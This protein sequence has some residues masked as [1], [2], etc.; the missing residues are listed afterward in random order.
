MGKLKSPPKPPAAPD[1]ER[2][3]KADDSRE[4]SEGKREIGPLPKVKNPARKA[5]GKKSLKAF[6]KAYFPRRF[7]LGFS[8]A[9]DTAIERMEG[10]TDNGELFAC[11]MPRGFGKTTIA[12]VAV[13]RA[14]LYGK[15]RFVVLVCATGPLAQRRL[16]Q[17][18]RELETNDLLLEDFPE[19]CYPIRKLDR[20]HNRAKGQTLNG[21]PTRMELNRDGIILPTV[22]GAA[23]SGA[24]IQVAGM[25]SAIR[26]MNVGGPDGEPL[27]PDM[28]VI[29][30][31]QTRDSA[32]SPIQTN[33]REAIV[34]G[35]VLGLAG[36]DVSMA[37]VMLCTV[38]YPGDL[39]E[40]FLDPEKHPEWQGVRT[41]TLDSF[42]A[43][44]DLWDEYA[45][46]RRQSFRDGSKGRRATEFYKKNRA[47][48]DAGAAPTWQDKKKPNELSAVQSAMNWFYTSRAA[49]MA[50]GQN[51]P[52]LDSGS[53][54]AK[55]LVP[56]EVTK[57]LSGCDRYVVPP[58]V[59]RLTAFIDCGGGKGRGLWYAVCG[60]TDGFG[61][62]VI[63]YGTWPRQVRTVFAADDMRPGLAELYPTLSVSERLYKGLTDLAAEV[64]PREYLRERTAER[65]R[66]ER[67]LVDV[68]WEPKTVWSWCR[69][70]PFWPI[71]TPSK[72]IA[73]TKTAKGVAEWAS[74]PGEPRPGHHW[75]L[76]ASELGQGR[77]CQFDTD[78]WKSILWER[79]TSPLGGA[80]CLHL[81]GKAGPHAPTHELLGEHLAA[82]TAEPVTIRGSTFDKWTERPHRPDNHWF[83]GL[84]GCAVGASMQGVTF[85][86][87]TAAG[88]PVQALAPVKVMSFSEMQRAARAARNGG[89]R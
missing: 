16:K 32:K 89:R 29:D 4:R 20:I 5:R 78:A 47:E 21:K 49:F 75:R 59:T 3:R 48:M 76:T 65:L 50:E 80:G 13:L 34:T 54:G 63:D 79:L 25:E 42:P 87:G 24:V 2:V 1:P 88:V 69:Q 27:R 71:V 12:E 37:A 81:Y 84:V 83:D 11:A 30:D 45:E 57:R 19:A 46:I 60:W 72:G 10:C 70:T 40:R 51:A 64:L 58:D 23:C 7:R 53:A 77:M 55:E 67:C 68:G 52:E 26:G 38:I 6:M 28:A 74:R 18:M 86:P 39:S 33:E 31:A 14:V 9:H 41:K 82:E 35:D 73:R 8:S 62:A 22:K 56:T 44:L 36:P 85:D 61:G 43:R 17:L 15:R 66:V